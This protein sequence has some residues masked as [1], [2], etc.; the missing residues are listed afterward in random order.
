MENLRADSINIY[1]DGSQKERP[2]RGGF[3]IVYV[4]EGA[5][6]HPQVIDADIV[7]P[8]F[9]GASNQQMEM[10]AVIEALKELGRRRYAPVNVSAFRRI[11][12]FTDSKY[13]LEGVESARRAWRYNGWVRRDGQPVSNSRLWELLL[14][15]EHKVSLPVYYVKVKGHS[16]NEYNNLADDQADRSCELQSGQRLPGSAVVR[17]K[18][19]PKQVRAGSITPAGQTDLIHVFTVYDER[20]EARKYKIEIVDEDSVDF[21]SVDFAFARSD[22]GVRAAHVYRVKFEGGTADLWIE[23]VLEEIPREDIFDSTVDEA[24]N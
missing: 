6:G 22:P 16:G 11:T 2:R 24:D 20:A 10:W 7:R 1:T 14:E 3:G 17:R 15:A 21:E 23:D 19:S 18:R 12:I 5:N 9:A 4:I 8:G 13:V